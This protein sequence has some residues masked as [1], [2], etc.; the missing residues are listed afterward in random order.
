MNPPPCDGHDLAARCDCPY[1][2]V[3]AVSNEELASARTVRGVRRKVQPHIRRG[4][5]VALEP[6]EKP[7][8]C[9]GPHDPGARDT[10]RR[11]PIPVYASD[12]SCFRAVSSVAG[13]R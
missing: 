11:G 9:E 1:A 4:P 13:E 5:T 3:P 8:P 2:L 6:F 7:V 10:L 12:G